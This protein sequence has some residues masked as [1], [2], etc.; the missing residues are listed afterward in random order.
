MKI[1]YY[2]ERVMFLFFEFYAKFLNKDWNKEETARHVHK[3]FREEV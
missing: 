2:S 3:M 1:V